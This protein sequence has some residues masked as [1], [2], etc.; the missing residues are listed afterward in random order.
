[1]RQTRSE[2]ER[3]CQKYPRIGTSNVVNEQLFPFS[4][5]EINVFTMGMSRTS[6]QTHF[7]FHRSLT[8]HSQSVIR[9]KN[10]FF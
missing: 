8:S 2:K 1:M 3:E 10:L 5:V 4:P 9:V 7:L 6:I